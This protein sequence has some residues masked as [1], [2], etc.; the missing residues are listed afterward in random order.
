MESKDPTV[1]HFMKTVL[2]DYQAEKSEKQAR[3]T[4]APMIGTMSV[5][6]NVIFV[7]DPSS[8]ALEAVLGRKPDQSGSR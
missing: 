4:P 6:G 1:N 2:A 3:E 7:G 5:Q 8:G